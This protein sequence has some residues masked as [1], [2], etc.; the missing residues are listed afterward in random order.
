MP[1]VETRSV[2]RY[3]YYDTDFEQEELYL[4][5][6]G[7][8]GYVLTGFTLNSLY[9][10][11]KIQPCS[12]VY[13]MDFRD[14]HDEDYLRLALDAGWL[15]AAT[16]WDQGGVWYYFYR[17]ISGDIVTELFTD[18]ESKLDF[19]RETQK[20]TILSMIIAAVVFILIILSRLLIKQN[21]HILDFIAGLVTGIITVL[22]VLSVIMYRRTRTKIKKIEENEL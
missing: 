5:S 14:R 10:F 3:L 15:L 11:R 20:R 12:L 19:L 17:T 16:R 18:S 4:S 7:K 8:K 21:S 1:K 22:F 2:F 9:K 6:M 13:K